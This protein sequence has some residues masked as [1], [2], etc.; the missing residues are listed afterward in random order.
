MGTRA[1]ECSEV[2]ELLSAFLD[3]ELEEAPRRGVA[4][5][6]KGCAACRREMQ[7]L[8]SLDEALGRLSAPAAPDV[9][10]RVLARL[11]RRRRAWWQNLALAASLVLGIVLGGT[12]A[13]D[14][15]PAPDHGAAYEM[16]SLEDFQD[17]PQG[18]LG[19]VLASYQVEEGN[20]T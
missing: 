3:G 5:H 11:H 2:K 1:P 12:V 7:L 20:G 9:A 4:A 19:T 6:L 18:S 14:F 15:Y 17:F 13:R 8:A 10:G 16:A